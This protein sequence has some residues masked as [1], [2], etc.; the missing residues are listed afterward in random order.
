MTADELCD[1]M[2]TVEI[3][4]VMNAEHD[5]I[6]FASPSESSTMCAL[7][8]G[9]LVNLAVDLLSGGGDAGFDEQVEVVS[10]LFASDTFE[11]EGVG[12]RAVGFES[13]ATQILV[14]G[15]RW[16]VRIAGSGPDEFSQEQAEQV[17]SL[18]AAALG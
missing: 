14:L 10:R 8:I 17:G 2:P 15:G 1:L 12:D 5:V 9:N 11:I 3:G 4:E 16:T 13:S 7:L 6:T 18:I